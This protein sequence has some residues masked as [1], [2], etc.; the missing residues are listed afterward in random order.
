MTRGSTGALRWWRPNSFEHHPDPMRAS[1]PTSTIL[2][3]SPF[4]LAITQTPCLTSLKR[5]FWGDDVETAAEVLAK[6]TDADWTDLGDWACQFPDMDD[7]VRFLLEACKCMPHHQDKAAEV[8]INVME[9][10]QQAPADVEHGPAALEH[11]LQASTHARWVDILAARP[12]LLARYRA[13]LGKGPD[14]T[15]ALCHLALHM[16]RRALFDQP[17]FVTR[18]PVYTLSFTGTLR[19]Q[20]KKRDKALKLFLYN[21]GKA[22][23]SRVT[24]QQFEGIRCVW[25]DT[26]Q[27][28]IEVRYVPR[29]ADTV[30]YYLGFDIEE[31]P[32]TEEPT[33]PKEIGFMSIVDQ[34]GP[35][36][37]RLWLNHKLSQ[38]APT[39]TGSPIWSPVAS[40]QEYAAVI[41]ELAG[42][43]LL[44]AENHV[45]FAGL[46]FIYQNMEWLRRHGFTL[47]LE[48][49]AAEIQG[50]ADDFVA[51]KPL[52]PE[53]KLAEPHYAAILERAKASGLPVLFVDSVFVDSHRCRSRTLSYQARSARFNAFAADRI[54][55]QCGRGKVV[56]LLGASHAWIDNSDD[57][58]R[59]NIPGLQHAL[60][61]CKSLY[62]FDI[63]QTEE[64]VRNCDERFLIVSHDQKHEM[65]GGSDQGGYRP[66][67]DV[68]IGARMPLQMSMVNSERDGL[69]VRGVGPLAFPPDTSVT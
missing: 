45:D 33:W 18:V 34:T 54:R 48:N 42:Y 38:P 39:G 43:N 25:T 28:V 7:K 19:E 58:A 3:P 63:V 13:L 65:S 52:A 44:I 37:E 24:L 46:N 49:L 17:G 66:M 27:P 30:R 10:L 12:D 59:A 64:E 29:V 6:A 16:A 2:R 32:Y 60:P 8:L 23:G 22:L 40:R 31:D 57:A 5:A 62:I 56:V 41:E 1:S 50:A 4:R 67:A 20:A 26:G 15:R 47:C 14:A 69:D 53:F 68:Y 36:F 9:E 21:A 35:E 55:A 11:M 61:N 51:G